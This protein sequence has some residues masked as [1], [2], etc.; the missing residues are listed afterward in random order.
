MYIEID[1][2]PIE[3]IRKPIKNIHLRIYPPDGQVKISVPMRYKSQLIHQHLQ[4]KITWISSQRERMQKSP[5]VHEEN[6]HN[7][8]S[9]HFLGKS[10]LL[11]IEEHF[12]PNHFTIDDQLIHCYIKPLASQKDIKNQLD[13]WYRR[14]LEVLVPEL[15]AHWQTIIG[16]RVKQWGIKKMKTRWGTCNTQAARVWLSLN[17]IKKPI[18]C[19]EY[20]IVHELVHLLEPSHNRRFYTLMT[21]FMPQWR[22]YEKILEGSM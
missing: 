20:V 19:L 15:I 9:I 16:V 3:I 13:R 5:A 6:L 1:G 7:G 17:L 10:Y 4:E 14:E 21:Q 11:V 22:E 8:S 2:I 18:I 12:G